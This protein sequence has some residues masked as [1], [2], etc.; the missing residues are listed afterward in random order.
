MAK[1]LAFS[2]V[3][4]TLLALCSGTLCAQSGTVRRAPGFALPDWQNHYV[5][6]SEHR[7][8]VVV[9][10]FMQTK[11]HYCHT[12]AQILEELYRKYKDQGLTVISVSHDPN[13]EKDVQPFVERYGLTYTF[14]LG[15]LGI[16]V[17]YIGITPQHSFFSIPYIFLIDRNGNIAGEYV[18]DHT[19][20]FFDNEKE[21]LEKEIV[22]LLQQKPGA[23]RRTSTDR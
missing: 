3:L 21:N 10:E 4:V 7:G 22:R 1:R 12:T 2:F 18:R 9:L 5:K 11:C 13:R 8:E 20:Q 14:V 19:P 15:D 6:L 16:A 17:R 23:L